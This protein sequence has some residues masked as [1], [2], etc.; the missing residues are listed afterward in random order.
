MDNERL[1]ISRIIANTLPAYDYEAEQLYVKSLN[2]AI[3]GGCL[4][5]QQL[6]KRLGAP[7][8]FGTE[9]KKNNDK[10]TRKKQK[11][12]EWRDTPS[13]KQ[14][15]QEIADIR[16]AIQFLLNEQYKYYIHSAEYIA[17]QHKNIFLCGKYDIES[18]PE[19]LDE[20]VIRKVARSYEWYSLHNAGFEFRVLSTEAIDL[21][22]WTKRYDNI[23]QHPEC[24][25]DDIINDDDLLDGWTS[26][27]A[28]KKDDD[29]PADGK[30]VFMVANSP[31][32]VKRIQEKNS[33]EARFAIKLRE[34][35][36]KNGELKENDLPDKKG[37]IQ[38]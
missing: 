2:E 17:T 3:F 6:L 27:I 36:M 37:I 21:I 19:R 4:T 31:E 38:F 9:I 20:A 24:P 33:P 18:V 35:K 26:Y 7:I 16:E 25:D 22:N 30:E 15:R 5:N 1:L 32:D 28:N 11:L 10:L 23:R 13:I 12:Y 14:Y 34:Q 8:S 29:D